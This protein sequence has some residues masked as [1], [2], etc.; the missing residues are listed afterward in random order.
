[1]YVAGLIPYLHSLNEW[2]LSQFTE[3]AKFRHRLSVWDPDTKQLFSLDELSFDN[4]IYEDEDLNCTEEPVVNILDPKGATCNGGY[5]AKQTL[6]F[7]LLL[8]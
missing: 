4:N 1:M 6:F 8:F 5:R 3:D 2:Y 7:Y